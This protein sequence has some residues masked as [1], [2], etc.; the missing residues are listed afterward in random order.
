MTTISKVYRLRTNLSLILLTGCCLVNGSSTLS[1][2]QSAGS[3]EPQSSPSR[4]PR[5][6]EVGSFQGKPGGFSSIQAAVDAALPGDWILIGP[7]HYREQGAPNAGVLITT[8]GVHLRGMDRNDV[9]IDGTKAGSRRCSGDPAAQD[10]G[11][12]AG[13]RNGIEILK[14]DG[15]SVENLTVCNFLSDALGHNGNQVWW[16]GGD[17]SGE[18]GIGSYAGAYLTASSTFSQLGIANTAQYGIFASNA[19]G[20]GLIT[21]SYASNMGDA[22]FYV[23]ACPDCNAVLRFVHAQNSAQG[24]SGTNAGGRLVL[25]YSEWDHNRAGIVSSTLSNDDPPSPQDGACPDSPGKSCTSIEFNYVH[26]NNNPNTPGLGLAASVPIGTG[27]NLSGGRSDTVRHNLVID[28]GSWGIL[29][30]DYPDFSPPTVPAYCQGGEVGYNPP[31]PFDQLYGPVIPC[32][33]PSFGNRILGNFFLGN[34]FFGNSTNGDMANAVLAHPIN[35]CFRDNFNAN[36]GTP[37]SSP[38]NLQAPSVAGT[39]GRPWNPDT[40][41]ELSLIEQVGCASQ[42]ICT[43]LPKPL[44][45]IPTKVQ[46]L[47]IPRERGMADACDGVPD[48]SWCK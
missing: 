37:T 9:V 23:G 38:A 14:V 44:Y 12:A 21:H 3:A 11:S 41:Q 6:L 26:D 22:A 7:G 30:N 29:L 16:N 25:E 43:G 4:K 32:Y 34:G 20:P 15:V 17:G 19:S 5:V 28:N 48:N 35:N 36:T 8:S 46:L 47:P 2:Q 42:G 33:F 24:F 31:P 10:Y 1:A 45:P 13:G 18:I 39:C 27:I 40:L